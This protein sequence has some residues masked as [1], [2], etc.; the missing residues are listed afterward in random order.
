MQR[1][2]SAT[3]GPNRSRGSFREIRDAFILRRCRETFRNLDVGRLE[4]TMPSGITAVV[5]EGRPD[6]ACNTHLILKNYGIFWRSLRRGTVGFAASYLDGQ[7][8]VNDLRNVFRFFL[9]NKAALKRAGRGWFQARLLDKAAHRR[10]A[11]TRKGSRRNIAAHY[12]LGNDFYRCWLDE[13]MTYSSALYQGDIP[14]EQAQADKYQLMVDL[15]DLQSGTSL[16]EIGC[17][18]GGMAESA[19][20]AGA[21]VRAITISQEQLRYARQRLNNAGLSPQASVE[22]VDYRDVDG[23]FDRIASIEM[24]EAVGQ[25]NWQTYFDTLSQR[26]KAGGRAAI[27][28]ITIDPDM[29]N[30]Y[31]RSP[32]FIQR[33]IFPGGVLPTEAIMERC[34]NAAGLQ[35]SR[36]ERFGASYARTLAEWRRRFVEAW[37]RLEGMG[38]DQRF[39]RMWL[40]YLT[41]CEVGFEQSTTN[42]GIYL[43]AK[44]A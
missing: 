17:G 24:I 28:A 20:R 22:F 5:F 11:N 40:Y 9:C 42:V 35:L 14:L 6:A 19:A 27:Q 7:F 25:E 13:G 31:A 12:D 33:F 43:F 21:Q 16:L 41:Y 23:E 30:D 3:T 1:R 32:D 26:L 36:V 29:F 4:I 39:R 34:A 8:E 18:W 44:P 10:R 37:P 38:F 15:L 2:N